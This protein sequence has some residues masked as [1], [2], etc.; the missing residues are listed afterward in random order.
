M[1]TTFKRLKNTRPALSIKGKF[2]AWNADPNTVVFWVPRKKEWFLQFAFFTLLAY[3]F[4]ALSI[5]SFL[6]NP[7]NMIAIVFSILLFILTLF[8]SR[9]THVF[10]R[11]LWILLKKDDQDEKITMNYSYLF[12]KRELVF[13]QEQLDHVL[14]AISSRTFRYIGSPT[15]NVEH[16]VKIYLKDDLGETYL[17]ASVAPPVSLEHI[18][19]FQEILSNFN[20]PFKE[21]RN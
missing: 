3:F 4:L 20:V 21:T 13:R 14:V 7:S 6:E 15:S 17:W 9:I 2:I 12:G 10:S 8:L 11:E 18:K 16:G 19:K 1:K 5:Y